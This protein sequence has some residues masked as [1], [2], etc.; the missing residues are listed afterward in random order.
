MRSFAEAEVDPQRL[1]HD[2]DEKFNRA[3]FRRCGE[4]GLL[5]VTADDAHGGGGMDATAVRRPP[6]EKGLVGDWSPSA[7]P[8]ETERHRRASCTRSSL[9]R[10]RPFA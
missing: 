6:S 2:R 7:A 1:E 9:P 10:T 3:L 5:G 4:L 8:G